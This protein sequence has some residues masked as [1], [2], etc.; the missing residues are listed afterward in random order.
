M[1]TFNPGDDD[2]VK[3]TY[4][5]LSQKYWIVAAREEIREWEKRMQLVPTAEGKDCHTDCGSTPSSSVEGAT[6]CL[7]QS[8][9]RLCRAIHNSTRQRK[10]SFKALYV[11]VYMYDNQGNTPRNGIYGLDTDSFLKAFYRMGNRRGFPA[12]VYSNNGGNFVKA[13][14]ELCELVKELNQSAIA[15]TATERRIKWHFNPPLAHT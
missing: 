10:V 9:S 2:I 3:M 5:V 11:S 4:S 14:K 8:V 13:N 12:E 6:T 15:K 7:Q 1:L